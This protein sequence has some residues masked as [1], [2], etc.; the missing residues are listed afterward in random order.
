[1]TTPGRTPGVVPRPA[2][3]LMAFGPNTKPVGAIHGTA[4][5]CLDPPQ[6]RSSVRLDLNSMA[7]YQQSPPVAAQRIQPECVQ[8]S[9]QPV[10]PAPTPQHVK[11]TP[12]HEQPTLRHT[13][14]ALQHSQ[15]TPQPIQ[16]ALDHPQYV[17]LSTEI[18]C[19]TPSIIQPVSQYIHPIT[20]NTS[21]SQQQKFTQHPVTGQLS[22]VFLSQKQ[23]SN[24][25]MIEG[26]TPLIPTPEYPR[27]VSITHQ[28]HTPCRPVPIV[29]SGTVTIQK[30]VTSTLRSDINSAECSLSTASQVVSNGT[31][32][33]SAFSNINCS[34]VT[35]PMK[36]TE[37]REN[38]DFT[39]VK[40]TKQF[41]ENASPKGK[42]DT[43]L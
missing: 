26:V 21:P 6:R 25:S 36:N 42:R 34:T 16:P 24:T 29:A 15:P 43:I 4:S 35:K 32:T 13:Q 9:L 17:Q 19:P 8:S 31:V 20:Q 14:L 39:N 7:S 33:K 30:Q 38:E 22:P 5:E 3:L 10:Q 27:T 18:A 28:T 41:T 1:M 40:R 37:E 2:S 11:L 23:N 12:H